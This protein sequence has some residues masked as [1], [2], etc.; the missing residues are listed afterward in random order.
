L[1]NASPLELG[2]TGGLD[3]TPSAAFDGTK[4][5]VLWSDENDA[6]FAQ[7]TDASLAIADGAT[8][9]TPLAT[10]LVAQT[11]VAA[12]EDNDALGP[13]F[14]V[15]ARVPDPAGASL[16][17]G[18]W[19]FD[20]DPTGDIDGD[21]VANGVDNCLFTPNVDQADAD[22]DGIGD[23]CDACPNDP[24][25]DVDGDGI[26][27]DVDN[28]PT[29]WN[30]AQ[31]DLDGDGIGDLCDPSFV[32][33]AAHP[34]LAPLRPRPASDDDER[35]GARETAAACGSLDAGRVNAAWASL[36]GLGAALL[37]IRLHRSRIVSRRRHS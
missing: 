32:D 25:N 29:V 27:G 37:A 6:A 26:C 4:L 5:L 16:S 3:Q 30:A 15:C 33:V 13:G 23:A 9:T 1:Q 11:P 36:G 14:F 7:R 20:D 12:F 21:G 34:H 2:A 24:D 28:C 10:K 8:I 19:R 31:L 35:S 18:T 22:Q 17:C